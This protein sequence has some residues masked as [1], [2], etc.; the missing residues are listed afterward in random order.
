MWREHKRAPGIE[1]KLFYVEFVAFVFKAEFATYLYL[2][3]SS[4]HIEFTFWSQ[5]ANVI[6]IQ[7]GLQ[8][9]ISIIMEMNCL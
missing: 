2:F 8:G 3:Y 7:S 6:L 5:A 1:N 4:F 9:R